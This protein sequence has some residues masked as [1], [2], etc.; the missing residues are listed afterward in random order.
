MQIDDAHDRL[1]AR[2]KE[3]LGDHKGDSLA[4]REYFRYQA[5]IFVQLNE[6]DVS[7]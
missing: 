5:K 3:K 7:G 4:S 6:D 1:E 2:L